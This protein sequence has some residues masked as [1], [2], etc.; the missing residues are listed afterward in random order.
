M[1]IVVG[2]KTNP[3]ATDQLVQDLAKLNLGGTLYLGYPVL[4]TPDETVLVDALLISENQGVV[5]FHFPKDKP[6]DDLFWEKIE[7]RHNDLYVAITQKLIGYKSLRKGRD[8]G[9][10]PVVRCYVSYEVTVPIDKE[11]LVVTRNNLA[12]IISGLQPIPEQYFKAVQSAIQRVSSIK[13]FKKRASV[14]KPD[15]KG[16]ILKSIEREIANLDTWQSHAAVETP[17]A[18]Q[19]IRGLAGSGKT[20]V[21]ALK[22]AFLH[23]RN[24]E[25]T[26]A[27]TFHT[28]SLYQQFR[29]LIRRFS[30]EQSGDEPDWSKL[31][32]IHSWGSRTEPGVY[33][34]IAFA[35]GTQPKNFE[36]ARMQ[37]GREGFGGICEEL[38]NNI[39]S[40]KPEYLYD[41]LMVDEAQDFPKSFFQL[42]Y[43]KAV[44]HSHRII[45]AYD[46]LQNL[47]DYV[48]LPPEELFGAD[49]TGNPVVTLRN[50]TGKPRQD[51]M[52]PVCYRNTPWALTV[53]HAVG[54]GVYR[55]G[56]LVQLFENASEA[57]WKRLGYSLISGTF[58]TG[59]Q[60]VLKRAEDSAPRYFYDL[61]SPEDSVSTAVFNNVQEQAK[62]VAQSIH[63]NLTEDELEHSDILV[64][65]PEPLTVKSEA[66]TLKNVLKSAGISSHIA[67]ITTSRDELFQD[68]SIAITG[69][70]RAKG[71]E[72]PM[73]Y[74]L[75]SE[76]ALEGPELI[77]RR[78]TLFT[79]ITRSKAWVRICGV[80]ERM[81]RLKSEVDKVV[82]NHFQL[83]FIVPSAG[84][85]A[86]LKK[87][88]REITRDEREKIRNLSD[89]VD[90][91]E[92]GDLSI[93]NIPKDLREKIRRQFGQVS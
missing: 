36:E 9:F 87:I 18:P 46:E 8:L 31:K 80:G 42:V 50:D 66:S 72:A 59:Q 74:I 79:A 33:S 68:N 60:V 10:Q 89:L 3:I 34:E 88:Y 75:N 51:I 84:E 5:L 27:V 76:Y 25:W 69:I 14:Q 37:Y 28:R 61:V 70:H 54:F 82:N 86:E 41:V 45:W 49:T 29:S 7:E 32:V 58:K 44:T 71:N 4:A 21:L 56:G 38:L 2:T 85:L 19:C 83:K 67:G 40:K 26:I 91:I 12:A 92:K 30:F 57:V 78:N 43:R 23:A 77:K 16:A 62:W 90:L 63:K 48:V 6:S 1:D 11:D 24:P 13:P 22:A 93:E 47:G 53:A 52:L 73:V 17:D 39:S 20:I 64:I 55:T 15:S 65:F 81:E 35:Y